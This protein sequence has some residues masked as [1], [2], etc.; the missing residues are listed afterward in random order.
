[1]LTIILLTG[2]LDSQQSNADNNN[3]V[4]GTDSHC[5]GRRIQGKTSRNKCLSYLTDDSIQQL[6][7]CKLKLM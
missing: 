4:S 3:F 6:Y 7:H 1:M 5:S 2:V